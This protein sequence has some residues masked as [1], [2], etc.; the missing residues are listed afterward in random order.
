M[1][2]RSARIGPGLYWS[3]AR[4]RFAD[5]MANRTRFAIGILSYFIY[6]SV[7]Y[8]IYRAVYQGGEAIGGLRLQEALSY[9]AVAWLLRS[10]YTNSLDRELTEEV[11]VSAS[12]PRCKPVS[13][14][15]ASLACRAIPSSWGCVLC[16]WGY[17]WCC[18]TP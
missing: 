15:A 6:I 13:F 3:F 1:L 12:T 14:N 4:V 17:S 11:S 10:L 9:V 16:C 18:P 8:S 5:L 2:S 7:Y